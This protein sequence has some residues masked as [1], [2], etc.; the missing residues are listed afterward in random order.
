MITIG[1]RPP[2]SD[3]VDLLLDCHERIRSFT[4]MAQRLA[5]SPGAPPAE[6]AEAAA[7][8]RHYFAEA[9]PLHARDEEESMVPRLRGRSPEVDRELDEMRREHA[10][11]EALLGRLVSLCEGLA[12]DP[13]R[14]GALAPELDLVATALRDHF[15]PHLDREER[16][17]FPALRALPEEQRTAMVRELRSRRA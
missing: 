15:V 5:R 8:V 4:S 3:I 11:H 10:E 2:A 6:V 9:L 13:A 14:H 17:L 16:V 1:K 12:A 7:K